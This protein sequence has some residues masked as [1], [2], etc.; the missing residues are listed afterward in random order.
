MGGVC[1]TIGLLR[2]GGALNNNEVMRSAQQYQSSKI[3]FSWRFLVIRIFICLVFIPVCVL[4]VRTFFVSSFRVTDDSMVPSISRGELFFSSQISYG[5]HLTGLRFRFPGFNNPQR[6][7]VVII[8]PP[9]YPKSD[10]KSFFEPAFRVLSFDSAFLNFSSDGIPLGRYLI[11]RIIG[12][13]GDSIKI[14][15][16]TAFIRP[17]GTEIFVSEIEL[18]PEI[19]I[20]TIDVLPEGWLPSF[21]L[22]GNY[23]EISLQEGEYFVLS[24][25]RRHNSDS[26]IW[27]PIS[28]SDIHGRVIFRYWPISELGSLNRVED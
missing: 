8:I 20:S 10:L 6:G 25:N 19:K 11:S 17:K 24:D 9:Y 12:I 21:P 13:P 16:S 26:R 7:D 15:E 28:K 14:Q 1:F 22:G 27:G 4:F 3:Q 2:G 5:A 23:A 18:M